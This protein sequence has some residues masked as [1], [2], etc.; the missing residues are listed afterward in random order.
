MKR[1]LTQVTLVVILTCMVTTAKK[2]PGYVEQPK[3]YDANPPKYHYG[4]EIQDEKVTQGKDEKRDGIYAQGR[5]YINKGTEGSQSVKYFADDWGYHPVVE[6]ENNGPY[7]KTRAKFVF[8][9][10]A[11]KLENNEKTIPEDPNDPGKADNLAKLNLPQ[12]LSGSQPA[13]SALPQEQLNNPNTQKSQ[14]VPLLNYRQNPPVTPATYTVLTNPS[15]HISQTNPPGGTRNVV[16]LSTSSPDIV[17]QGQTGSTSLNNNFVKTEPTSSTAQ[18]QLI[19]ND[20]DNGQVLQPQSVYFVRQQHDIPNVPVVAQNGINIPKNQIQTSSQVLDYPYYENQQVITDNKPPNKQQNYFTVVPQEQVLIKDNGNTLDDKYNQN[21]ETAALIKGPDEVVG[22]QQEYL[23]TNGGTIS[24]T[25]PSIN[26]LI[27]S[28]KNLVTGLDVLNINEAFDQSNTGSKDVETNTLE[29]LLQKYVTPS[30]APTIGQTVENNHLQIVPSTTPTPPIVTTQINFLRQPIIV[31]ESRNEKPVVEK[32]EENQEQYSTSS[33]SS[34]TSTTTETPIKK[35]DGNAEVVVTPRPVSSKFLAPITAGIQL[36]SIEEQLVTE[37]NSVESD[38]SFKNDQVYVQVQKTLPFY[39][40]MYQYPTGLGLQVNNETRR[41]N[42]VSIEE[43]ASENME[44]GKTLLYFPGE[45]TSGQQLV[46][47]VSQVPGLTGDFSRNIVVGVD[48]RT[49][50]SENVQSALTSQTVNKYV[51]A[52]H[53][54]QLPP[55]QYADAQF[56]NVRIEPKISLTSEGVQ[57]NI[58]EQRVEKVE[59][60]IPGAIYERKQIF[61]QKPAERIIEKPAPRYTGNPYPAPPQAYLL[62]IP[63]VFSQYKYSTLV[64]N[65]L[66]P[67]NVPQQVNPVKR[68]QPHKLRKLNLLVFPGSKSG[69]FRNI[70][71]DLETSQSSRYSN[72]QLNNGYLPPGSQKKNKCN[73][74]QTSSSQIH[75][76][77]VRKPEQYIGPIPPRQEMQPPSASGYRSARSSFDEKSI[78]LEYGFMPPLI[79]SLE[80]DEMGQPIHREESKI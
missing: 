62:Q 55:I 29:S 71:G 27:E 45:Q 74:P 79:P 67:N 72:A 54:I 47:L 70:L 20:Q 58:Q 49:G 10:E 21:P 56:G 57:S 64:R 11:I 46:N 68:H 42:Q 7:S 24:S 63:G 30:L 3:E 76:Q 38:E 39:L 65:S 48:Q 2:P 13:S 61:V 43:R 51:D 17:D 80:I 53:S 25:P 32:T 26:K 34:L 15:T 69:Q 19:L 78:R 66:Q 41:G 37:S 8:G 23:D 40:G 44:L 16:I 9:A 59:Y 6:Y 50:H 35:S 33:R 60:N 12:S 22:I 28:T 52:S 5:Y 4:Y 18:P 1:C 75:S 36:Q 77:V 14:T 31:A 73:E